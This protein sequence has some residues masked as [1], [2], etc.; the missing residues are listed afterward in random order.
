MRCVP[1]PPCYLCSVPDSNAEYRRAYA[2]T[3][4][5]RC[6]L[7]FRICCVGGSLSFLMPRRLT[8]PRFLTHAD[9]R[10][11][12]GGIHE[13][14]NHPAFVEV[15]WTTLAT[16]AFVSSSYYRFTILTIH[17]LSLRDRADCP[18][19]PPVLL[20]GAVGGPL[21]C[22]RR[23]LLPLPLPALCVLRVVPVLAHERG[24]RRV[25]AAPSHT[26]PGEPR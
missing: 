1:P 23:Y 6:R 4:V 26:T 20:R 25:A 21:R 13:I 10:L 9:R 24:L 5:C 7:C 14:H 17:Y 8:P 22:G 12:R 18:T 3:R 16:G 19:P 11:G 2:S 15:N